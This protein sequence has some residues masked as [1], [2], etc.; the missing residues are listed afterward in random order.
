MLRA[1]PDVTPMARSQVVAL[2]GNSNAVC[3][4]ISAARLTPIHR[5]P[6]LVRVKRRLF[7][8]GLASAR[9]P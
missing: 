1:L 6:I 5:P 8:D 4:R 2:S 9:M 7:R 3:L